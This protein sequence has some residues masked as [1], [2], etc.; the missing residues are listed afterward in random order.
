MKVSLKNKFLIPTV[1]IIIIGM[2]FF[3]FFAFARAKSVF[4]QVI[5]EEIDNVAE[6]TVLAMTSWI[7]DRKIDIENWSQQKLYASA[8]HP[9]FLGETAR[10]F[11]RLQLLKI[12]ENYGYY[13]EIGIVDATGKCIVKS[14]NNLI[15]A[16]NVKNQKYFQEAMKGKVHV[17]EEVVKSRLTGN[18][19]FMISSPIMENGKVT[20][21]CLGI[22]KADA[23]INRFVNIIQI[24]ENGYAYVFKEDGQILALSGKAKILGPNIQDHD[25]GKKMMRNQEG[26]LEYELQNHKMTAVFK[27]FRK[28]GW[29]IVV[30]AQ[31]NEILAPVKNL[32]T[33]YLFISFVILILVICSILFIANSVTRPINILVEGLKKMGKGD[34]SYRII[35]ESNDEIGDIGHALNKMAFNLEKSQNEINSQNILLMEARDELEQK[36]EKRTRKL[37]KTEEEY[38]SIFENAVEGIF[39][40]T[41]DGRY[42]NANPALARIMGYD[43]PANLPLFDKSLFVIPGDYKKIKTLLGVGEEII[44]FETRI[45]QKGNSPCWCSI[46]VQCIKDHIGNLKYYEGSIID[47]SER[48]EKEKAQNERE[49]AVA[50][51]R[52]K[53]KFLANI[54]HEIRTPLNAVIGFCGLLSSISIDPKQTNY[55]NSIKSAGKSLLTLINDILDLSKMEAGRFKII[56]TKVS[57][58]ALANEIEQMFK[59]MA[60][61][62]DLEFFLEMKNDFVF[63]LLVDEIRLRQILVNLV[64]NAI[65]FTHQGYI[66]IIL[67]R[68]IKPGNKNFCDLHISVQD[69]GIGIDEGDFERIFESFEQLEPTIR[70]KYGGTGL[71]LPICKRLVTAMEGHIEVSSSPG[72][73]ST[74]KIVLKNVKQERSDTYLEIHEDPINSENM[75]SELSSLDFDKIPMEFKG[76]LRNEMLPWSQSLKDAVVVNSVKDFALRLQTLSREYEIIPLID[77][78]TELIEFAD[79]FDIHMIQ[80]KLNE[81]SNLDKIIMDFKLREPA[82]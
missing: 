18:L 67:R 12:K 24:G 32:Q 21:V 81:F 5:I 11:A 26:I 66:K 1:V 42:I 39:R 28:I 79:Y 2:G 73:G 7:K 9:T 53:S 23:F 49:A 33:L 71:G 16:V 29:T 80:R 14:G 3:A 76:F 47:I 45:L 35:P 31:T 57:I 4:T 46:S 78:S 13:E 38:R 25:F 51:S 65:K 62:K 54:S 82:L 59:P 72:R 75:K 19:V 77:F 30:C 36:V 6:T 58:R 55:I 27:K 37:R 61:D 17:S 50:A 70:K 74:F 48:I 60:S 8:L 69:T 41:K 68:K 15:S 56:K 20:G 63:C 64:G 44:G 40:I 43:D 52:L 34:L 10:T 22:L